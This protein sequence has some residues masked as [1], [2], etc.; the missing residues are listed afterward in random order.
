VATDRQRASVTATEGNFSRSL[1]RAV[2]IGADT[3]VTLPAKLENPQW[4]VANGDLDVGFTAVPAGDFFVVDAFASSADGAKFFSS[5]L[6]VSQRFITEGGL[7]HG[8][9]DTAIP[10]FKPEWRIDFNGAF[11]RDVFAFG[12]TGTDS[13]TS[14]F[15]ESVNQPTARIARPERMPKAVLL[16]LER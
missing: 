6:E 9:L 7:L 5:D 16:R 11:T 13:F 4:S 14:S 3:N 2:A 10:G 1:S 15:S 8:L 12:S